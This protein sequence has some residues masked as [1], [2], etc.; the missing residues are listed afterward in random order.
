MSRKVKSVSFN[1]SDQW[2]FE[3]FEYANKFPNFSSFIKRLIQNAMTGKS[4]NIKPVHKTEKSP[5]VNMEIN[6][7]H[8]KQLI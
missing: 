4:E 3:M 5:I 2:E 6:P 7:E 8:L 1:L